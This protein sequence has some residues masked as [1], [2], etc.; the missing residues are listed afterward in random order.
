MMVNRLSIIAGVVV[1]Q[2]ASTNALRGSSRNQRNQHRQLDR[3]DDLSESLDETIG[4]DYYETETGVN[5]DSGD[6][7]YTIHEWDIDPLDDALEVD[8]V[9]EP[10]R[11]NATNTT[12][13]SGNATN[14]T[15]TTTGNT[16]NTTTSTSGNA[17]DNT[18]TS[19]T[20][21]TSTCVECTNIP[22]PYMFDNNFHCNDYSFAYVERCGT[23]NSWW[24]RDGNVEH[25]QYSCWLNDVPFA[26]MG[27][28]SC[29]DRNDNDDTIAPIEAIRHNGTDPLL[30]EPGNG[31]GEGMLN[32]CQGDW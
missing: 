20:N 14:T 11:G 25:C 21:A 9:D 8:A 6:E 2:I 19:N 5:P 10:I 12:I 30:E 16:A 22:T 18:T 24:G 28:A 1:L 31:L 3:L 27:N 26:S 29:C 23:N 17:T 32:I 13:T 4:A 7:D 15:A